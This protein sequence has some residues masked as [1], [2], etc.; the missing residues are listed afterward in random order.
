MVFARRAEKRLGHKSIR[1]PGRR[2]SAQAAHR[3][4]RWAIKAYNIEDWEISFDFGAEPPAWG[5]REVEPDD[6]GMSAC[7]RR[8]KSAMVWVSPQRARRRGFAWER[9]LLHEIWHVAVCDAGIEP[10]L[11]GEQS[12]DAYETLW[13]RLDGLVFAAYMEGYRPEE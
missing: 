9:I 12:P 13:D 5:Q 8:R 7:V 1:Q 2:F 6:S 4:A 10:A 11:T 3:V